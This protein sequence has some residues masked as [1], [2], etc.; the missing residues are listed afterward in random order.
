MSRRKEEFEVVL[1]NKQLLGMFFMA[2]AFFAVAFVGG[3][4]LGY[5]RGVVDQPLAVKA[6]NAIE[7]PASGV[8][9]PET[10]LE[11]APK[12]TPA[13]VAAAKVEEPPPVAARQA[14]AP[15]AKTP[16]AEADKPKPFPKETASST[17][18][19]A[20]PAAAAPA[21]P[22]AAA[23]SGSKAD[24][25]ANSTHVQVAAVRVAGDAAMLAG[26]L[27]AKGYPAVV[28]SGGSD[29][30]HRVILGPYSGR[31]DAKA[32]QAKLKADGLDSLI[33]VH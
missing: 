20:R 10:L 17:A 5:K 14:P 16:I 30:L 21:P 15:V 11:D 23:K 31:D 2:V 6:E 1:G 3:F 13:P 25:I 8:Q 7:A 12:A 18:A 22:T 32:A 26:K 19:A 29:G 33:R 9:L 24:T 28:Y 4:F 27:T